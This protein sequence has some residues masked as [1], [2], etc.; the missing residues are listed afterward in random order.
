MRHCPDSAT[1]S[2]LACVCKT[3]SEPCASELRQSFV[4]GTLADFNLFEG[5][6]R[7]HDVRSLVLALGSRKADDYRSGGSQKLLKWTEAA[8]QIKIS[9]LDVGLIGLPSCA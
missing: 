2:A 3:F 6:S 9:G 4:I 7:R 8:G 5:S 1:L